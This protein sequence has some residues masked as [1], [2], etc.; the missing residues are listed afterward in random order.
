MRKTT[1]SMFSFQAVTGAVTYVL[2]PKYAVTAASTYDFGIREAL[3]N[4]VV[5]T[6]MGT[7]LQISLGFTYN[8]ITNNVGVL[9][10]IVPNL[11]P[12]TRRVGAISALG[13]GGVLSR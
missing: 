11:L 1:R 9:F 3:S 2:S 10:E 4:S 12:P 7:D 5:F 13:Q 6:R 8:A